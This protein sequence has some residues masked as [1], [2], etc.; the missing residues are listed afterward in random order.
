MFLFLFAAIPA[1]L[2]PSASGCTQHTV[3]TRNP[4]AAL[5]LGSFQTL[6]IVFIVV[7][8]CLLTLWDPDHKTIKAAKSKKTCSA[9]LGF[10]DALRL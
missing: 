10:K 4:V 8:V 2:S 7:P 5:K 1:C 9:T 3:D 6:P